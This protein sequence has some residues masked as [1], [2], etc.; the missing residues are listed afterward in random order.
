MSVCI[1]LRVSSKTYT[2][3]ECYI[4]GVSSKMPLGSG[5]LFPGPALAAPLSM[6]RNGG[7][8]GMP[9]TRCKLLNV[10]NRRRKKESKLSKRHLSFPPSLPFLVKKWKLLSCGAAEMNLS[11][12][13]EDAGLI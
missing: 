2:Y 7:G 13:H 1:I 4:F 8:A 3:V 6:S 10:S 11:S 5:L 9:R 12:I